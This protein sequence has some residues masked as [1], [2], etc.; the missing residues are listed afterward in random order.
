[1]QCELKMFPCSVTIPAP[2]PRLGRV[3]VYGLIG[4]PGSCMATH[5]VPKLVTPDFDAGDSPIHAQGRRQLPRLGPR[6]VLVL[7]LDIREHGRRASSIAGL[8]A[9]PQRWWQYSQLAQ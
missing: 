1:M 9:S 3:R 5:L 8:C 2:S 6:D 4:S 7:Q